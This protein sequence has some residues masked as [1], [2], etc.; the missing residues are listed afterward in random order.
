VAPDVSKYRDNAHSTRHVLALCGI[1]YECRGNE[2]RSVRPA[3]V[4]LPK[5]LE[6]LLYNWACLI[7]FDEG[8]FVEIGRAHSTRYGR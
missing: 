6:M 5:K 8:E 1:T 7:E 2:R 3:H 4:A